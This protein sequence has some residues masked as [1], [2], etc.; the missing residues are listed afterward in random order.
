MFSFLDSATSK[1]LGSRKVIAQVDN[2]KWSSSFTLDSA[3]VIQ[4]LSV[5]HAEMGVLELSFKVNTAP[6]RLANY[7]KIVRFSPRFVVIN[8]LLLPARIVQVNGF[9][10]E[11]QVPID[12]A[13]GHL[14]PFH[15]PTLFGERQ[16]AIQLN[17]PWERSVAIDIDKLNSYTM[18]INR[19]TD[20]SKLDHILT[21][22]APEYN[23]EFENGE[24]GIWFETDW[25]LKIV[26]MRLKPGSYAATRTDVTVGDVLLCVNGVP[27]EGQSFDEVMRRL[28]LLQ[29]D[30]G[31]EI[32]FQTVEQKLRLIRESAK[33]QAHE[34][35]KEVAPKPTEKSSIVGRRRG[36][37]HAKRTSVESTSSVVQQPYE[38]K[39]SI[40]INVE[41]RVVDSSVFMI[42]SEL[43]A[44]ARPEYRVVNNSHCNVIYYRQK[45]IHDGWWASLDPGMSAPYIW[46]NPNKSHRLLIRI[47]ANIL[48]PADRSS[49][50]DEKRMG[51]FSGKTSEKN[52]AMINFDVIGSEE[53]IYVPGVDGRLKAQ[54]F[55]E[56]P[57]KVLKVFPAGQVQED[58]E[59][60]FSIDFINAQIAI[61]DDLLDKVNSVY[62]NGS[63]QDQV[64]I[65][66]LM[67]VAQ[68]EIISKQHHLLQVQDHWDNRTTDDEKNGLTTRV[69]FQ[70]LFGPLITRQDQ[71]L[72]EVI[73]TAGTKRMHIGGKNET[74]CELS[75]RLQNASLV[76]HYK[77]KQ[78]TYVNDE[79][80]NP[81]WESQIFIF[82]VPV[83]PQQSIRGYCVRVKVKSKSYIGPDDFL[84][85]AD[86]QF[87][88]LESED[89]LR[90][91][92]PLQ[93]QKSSIKSSP[94][95][96]EV[97]GSIKLRVQWIHSPKALAQHVRKATN[98]RIDYLSDSLHIQQRVLKTA[99]NA[100]ANVPPL[101]RAPSMANNMGRKKK[102]RG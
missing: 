25:D 55:S 41:M 43:D 56:G 93:P 102:L 89:E 6:G 12:I 68:D 40:P 77:Q 30:K 101:T 13:H 57:T 21:R 75:L 29:A 8:K 24:I 19:K 64:V 97:T 62:L 3:G 85:Q 95:S 7:T 4:T 74:Y 9:R 1:L 11:Q 38:N 44:T 79:S 33:S 58:K 47:G 37:L 48:C 76:K 32:T 18:T 92:F 65:R 80:L 87:A 39:G 34:V 42:L 98:K 16:L 51:F 35:Q 59:L 49:A 28:K 22:G 27:V 70:S 5:N 66:D 50:V 26:V 99:V 84:G 86:I 46:D 82:D 100:T 2:S 78:K 54:I 14:R 60:H 31:C 94:Q 67:N 45:G 91:W 73:S 72:V 96:L 81:K 83:K 90:G 23:V 71:L 36:S 20:T 53:N 69:P 17:G 52:T 15:L 61:L 63:N 88:S 10:S